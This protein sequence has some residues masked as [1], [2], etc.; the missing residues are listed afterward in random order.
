M[1]KRLMSEP[2]ISWAHYNDLKKTLKGKGATDVTKVGTYGVRAH[3]VNK[4]DWYL[5]IWNWGQI[6]GRWKQLN[7]GAKLIA[8]LH[9]GL[10]KYPHLLQFRTDSCRGKSL[11]NRV[12]PVSVWTYGHKMRANF[13]KYFWEQYRAAVHADHFRS[14]E[15]RSL[16]D[17]KSTNTWIARPWTPCG[18]F[19]ITDDEAALYPNKLEYGIIEY[20]P[21]NK[22]GK[23]KGKPRSTISWKELIQ[24]FPTLYSIGT[25]MQDNFMMDCTRIHHSKSQPDTW[26]CNTSCRPLK[27]MTDTFYQQFKIWYP[28]ITKRNI[29]ESL[30]A[31]R[32]LGWR[33]A[34]VSMI[35][36][37]LAEDNPNCL[38][39]WS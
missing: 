1:I 18:T 4:T 6:N 38:E 24:H 33:N 26:Y 37:K 39:E 35:L 21:R 14:S 20:V 3:Y 25:L 34:E 11:I 31:F 23:P 12:T 17:Q 7:G 9:L 29:Y 27:P 16:T 15:W 36:K 30:R 22:S 10:S 19:V 5:L 13:N 28:K 2:D 8:R 32:D